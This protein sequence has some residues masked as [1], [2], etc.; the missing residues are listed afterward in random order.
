[1]KK[2]DGSVKRKKKW[3]ELS[4]RARV[5]V[6]LVAVVQVGLL[7]AAQWDIQHRPQKQ[8]NGPKRLWRVVSLVNFIGPLAYFG[9]GR[10]R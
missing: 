4:P 5:L 10:K 6:V 9:F 3:S 1:M 7:A 8:I 2:D